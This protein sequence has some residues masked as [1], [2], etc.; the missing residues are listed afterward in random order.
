MKMSEFGKNIHDN[1]VKLKKCL[2]CH[3]WVMGHGWGSHEKT[4]KM[5]GWARNIALKTLHVS[6]GY[7]SM[8]QASWALK[9][10]SSCLSKFDMF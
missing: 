5:G 8:G 2:K 4:W 10:T 3:G 1:D 7:V 6:M 9:C